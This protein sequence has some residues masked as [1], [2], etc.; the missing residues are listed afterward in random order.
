MPKPMKK[1]PPVEDATLKHAHNEVAAV[2]AWAERMG[3]REIGPRLQWATKVI[4]RHIKK[5][6]VS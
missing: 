3:Y 5:E 1:L 4:E 6:D 2:A